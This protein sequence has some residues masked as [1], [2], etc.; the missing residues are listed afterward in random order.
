MSNSKLPRGL[1]NNNPGNIEKSNSSWRGKVPHDQNTD[2]RFEQFQDFEGIP[3]MTWGVRALTKLGW[4]YLKQR[5]DHT[6][7]TFFEKYAPVVENNTNAYANFVAKKVGAK[8][9]DS[10]APIYNDLVKQYLFIL[11][12]IQHE[13]GQ[14]FDNEEVSKGVELGNR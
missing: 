11:A 8:S 2:G 6:I 4:T 1:R 3:A 13:N 5:P 7:Q 14:A 12:I 9:S 10:L